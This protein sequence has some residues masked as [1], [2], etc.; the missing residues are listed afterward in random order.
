MIALKIGYI[1]YIVECQRLSRQ[2]FGNRK[3]NK[4]YIIVIVECRI[5]P[6]ARR[7]W[8]HVANVEYSFSGMG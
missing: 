1:G 4:S 5:V 8:V 3:S 6:R 7:L 2:H